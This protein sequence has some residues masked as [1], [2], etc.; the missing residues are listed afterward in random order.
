M[1]DCKLDLWPSKLRGS[2]PFFLLSPFSNCL[3]AQQA[4]DDFFGMGGGASAPQA[5]PAQPQL[6]VL[7]PA[8][9]GKGLAISGR[10]ARERSQIG[11]SAC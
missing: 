6:P 7:L 5:S 11:E 9:K 3:Q 8:D 10:L 2:N 4:Q 1:S